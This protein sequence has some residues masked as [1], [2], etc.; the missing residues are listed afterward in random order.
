DRLVARH[1]GK[2]QG[3]T[4]AEMGKRIER[5]ERVLRGG[6]GNPYSGKKL[7]ESSCAPCHTLF[8]RGGP[9]GPAPPASKRG[10]L[11]NM[12]LSIVNPSAEIR[13]GFE[14]HLAVT[15][16]G[17]ALTGFV[18]ERDNRVVVLRGADGQ[19]VVL[20]REGLEEL[21]PVRQSLMPEGLL[22]ALGD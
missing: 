6:T 10:D 4:T 16:D 14:T 12:L 7:F 5:Y 2:V 20:E 22:D 13:E 3:A 9:A 11:A 21:R 19:D 18:V 8:G 17:R 1:W 15:R